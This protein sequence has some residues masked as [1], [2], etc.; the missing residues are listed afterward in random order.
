MGLYVDSKFYSVG[1]HDSLSLSLLLP[2]CQVTDVYWVLWSLSSGSCVGQMGV[3][4][5]LIFFQLTA[6]DLIGKSHML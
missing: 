5:N 3:T 1:V 2:Y 6:D 4:F